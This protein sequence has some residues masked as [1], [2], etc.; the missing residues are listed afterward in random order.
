MLQYSLWK[1]VAL[2]VDPQQSY[3]DLDSWFWLVTTELNGFW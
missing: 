1:F 2:L 3:P